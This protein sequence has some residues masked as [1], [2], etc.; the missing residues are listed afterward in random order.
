MN[1]LRI[2]WHDSLHSVLIFFNYL[3]NRE[4]EVAWLN[5]LSQAIGVHTV[6]FSKHFFTIF[7]YFALNC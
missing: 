3:V 1:L 4:R 2:Q 7:Q 5:T 6:G